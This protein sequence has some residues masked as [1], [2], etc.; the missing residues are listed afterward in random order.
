MSSRSRRQS[1]EKGK[2]KS[3]DRSTEWS[4]W[5][6][7]ED[8]GCWIASRTGPDGEPEYDYRLPAES[9]APRGNSVAQK[10]SSVSLDTYPSSYSAEPPQPQYTSDDNAFPKE[11]STYI[12]FTHYPS[13]TAYEDTPVDNKPTGSLHTDT[14]TQTMSGLT[15]ND[16]TM[17]EPDSDVFLSQPT[18]K[19]ISTGSSSDVRTNQ[20]EQGQMSQGNPNSRLYGQQQEYDATGE[21]TFRPRSDADSSTYKKDRRVRGT[22][23]DSEQLD[24]SYKVRK[25]DYKKFFVVGKVFSTL[26]T[27]PFEGARND[28]TQEFVTFTSPGQYDSVLMSR[29][30]RFVVVKASNRACTCL[31]VTSYQ[32]LGVNKDRLNLNEHGVIYSHKRPQPVAGMN[33]PPLKIKL[34][35]RNAPFRDSSLINYGRVYTVETNVKVKEIGDLDSQSRRNLLANFNSAFFTDD[36]DEAHA[37]SIPPSYTNVDFGGVGTGAYA[38]HSSGATY[39]QYASSSDYATGT[40]SANYPSTLHSGRHPYSYGTEPI[41][42]NEQGN[43]IGH[44]YI[45]SIQNSQQPNNSSD[46]TRLSDAGPYK[47]DHSLNTS[48]HNASLYGKYDTDHGSTDP[49]YGISIPSI[50]DKLSTKAPIDDSFDDTGV[51]G[52]SV[53]KSFALPG[54][55]NRN[56][57][58]RLKSGNHTDKHDSITPTTSLDSHKDPTKIPSM[59]QMKSGAETVSDTKQIQ[60]DHTSPET[61]E[62]QFAAAE[63][64]QAGISSSIFEALSQTFPSHIKNDFLLEGNQMIQSSLSISNSPSTASLST[65]G[66]S[67]QTNPTSVFSVTSSPNIGERIVKFFLD[68]QKLK[69]SLQE[70]MG[71]VSPKYFQRKFRQNLKLFSEDLQSENARP[72]MA[73]AARAIRRHSRNTAINIGSSLEDE[74]QARTLKKTRPPKELGH[75]DDDGLDDD[76]PEDLN[77][78]P[79]D[80]DAGDG[81]FKEFEEV[82]L[83]SAS[84]QILRDRLELLVHPNSIREALLGTWPISCARTMPFELTYKVIWNARNYLKTYFPSGQLLGDVM[85]LSGDILRAQA[86]SC[87]DYLKIF[88]PST[89]I[90][91]LEALEN[92]LQK[93]GKGQTPFNRRLFALQV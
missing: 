50:K 26:W 22:K 19:H 46:Y 29:I 59:Y 91:V 4:D 87:R 67:Y 34:L 18:N 15:I 35:K 6:W 80:E 77:D 30:R 33:K 65:V 16:G 83:A 73:Q 2:G 10:A 58:K 92:M 52:N 7:D 31:P 56:S 8:N 40:S 42:V 49:S 86:M 24:S 28:Q 39:D 82:L 81:F 62:S 51:R 75:D 85:T 14:P 38:G 27:E 9:Q 3:I 89:G 76:G 71:S 78:N 66:S 93:G 44:N 36:G 57:L 61:I 17:Y 37:P 12:N 69:R 23:G 54:E 47:N 72:M 68:D 25:K 45:I 70:A 53:A 84:L 74:L 48:S 20:K 43:T 21:Y 63:D 79:N 5:V 60:S 13:H 90:L 41:C 88:W 11:Q 32:G 55:D 1:K 64:S